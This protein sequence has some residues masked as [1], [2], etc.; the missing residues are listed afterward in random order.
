MIK[1][2]KD[3]WKKCKVKIE[4]PCESKRVAKDIRMLFIREFIEYYEI[5]EYKCVLKE[6]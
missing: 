6:I 1:P 3:Y 5:K 4:I 2:N